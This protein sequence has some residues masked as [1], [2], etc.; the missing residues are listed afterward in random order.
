MIRS[1][2]WYKLHGAVWSPSDI[3]ADTI[4]HPA[5]FSR[6]LIRAIYDDAAEWYG[7]IGATNY[8]LDPFA[9]T[10]LG[11]FDAMRHDMNWT[12]VEIVKSYAWIGHTNI[13]KWKKKF[14]PNGKATIFHGDSMLL[15]VYAP[16]PFNMVV[17]SPPYAD[18]IAGVGEGPGARYDFVNHNASTA[19]R[20]TSTNAYGTAEAQLASMPVGD[21]HSREPGTFW[22]AAGVVV[23]KVYQ[24]CAPGAVAYWNTRDFVRNGERVCF[25][26]QWQTLC[27]AHGFEAIR[28]I[29]SWLVESDLSGLDLFGNEFRLI[30]ERKSM[31]RRAAEKKGAPRIDW[32]D[33][34]VMVK[35]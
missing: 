35:T 21:V 7:R 13:A 19:T 3:H 31:W 22:H 23:S 12:G 10:A 26:S 33:V 2:D 24:A 30:K 18:V 11:A 32:E 9:G 34:I 4:N 16:G 28:H 8:V 20:I 1:E 27:E 29:R 5:R 6:N 25:G 17:S 15:D 14:F